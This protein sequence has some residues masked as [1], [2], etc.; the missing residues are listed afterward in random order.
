MIDPPSPIG[1]SPATMGET[2]NAMMA[3]VAPMGARGRP[4]LLKKRRAQA[5]G[6][7]HDT[8]LHQRVMSDPF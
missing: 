5:T 3:I 4:I 8:R 6:T 7:Q 1:M 2:N